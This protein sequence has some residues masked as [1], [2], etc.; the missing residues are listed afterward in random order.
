MAEPKQ[1][2]IPIKYE[3]FIAIFIIA[4]VF[5]AV[6]LT[7]FI[8]SY[9]GISLNEMSFFSAYRVLLVTALSVIVVPTA[10]FGEFL[11]KEWKKRRF[12]WRSVFAG[13]S[14]AGIFV[15]VTSLMLTVFDALLPSID[16]I[17][18]IP[19]AV[20]FSSAGLIIMVVPLRSSRFKQFAR[21]NLGW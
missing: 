6:W 7:F 14:I 9:L 8:P 16:I 2:R 19:L 15:I 12:L 21:K 17:G 20:I 3:I 1:E 11:N 13:I 18:Q 10:I 4:I 5:P